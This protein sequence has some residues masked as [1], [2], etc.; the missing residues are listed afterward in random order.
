MKN[1]TRVLLLAQFPGGSMMHRASLFTGV[2]IPLIVN[3]SPGQIRISD[4]E[5]EG[6]HHFKIET[7][8]YTAFY[9]VKGGGFSRLIDPSGVDWIAFKMEPW[10]KSPAAAASAFRGLPNLVFR[11]EDGGSGHPGFDKCTSSIVSEDK[12]KSKSVSGKW[13]WEWTFH[14]NHAE[15]AILETDT[16]RTYW[17]LYEG[18]VGG[19]YDPKNCLWANDIHGFRSDLVSL[20]QREIIN[21]DWRW[22]SFGHMKHD[23]VLSIVQVSTDTTSDFYSW[24]GDNQQGIH[25]ANG[26]M[27]FGFGRNMGQPL[28]KGPNKYKIGFV[29]INPIRPDAYSRVQSEIERWRPSPR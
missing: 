13:E 8:G 28:L 10:D 24:M 19:V 7:K 5:Y 23:Y 26:M 6:R 2:L 9:D 18:P 29:E 14:E 17:F 15:L 21:G 20:N 4:E 11:G 27:V 22:V 3:S 12:I 16:S 1:G 25:A